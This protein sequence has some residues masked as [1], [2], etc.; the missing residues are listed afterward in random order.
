MGLLNGAVL[1]FMHGGLSHDIQPAAVDWRIGTL[2][3]AGGA[4]L[5]AAQGLTPASS[6]LVAG[7]ATVLGGMA[8]Y[9]RALRRFDGWPDRAWVFAP[10][11]AGALGIHW[12]AS[13]VPDLA[14]RVVMAS[15]SSALML[16][17]ASATVWRGSRRLGVELPREL[18]SPLRSR[19]VLLAFLLL[20]AGFML[21]RAAYALVGLR[22]IASILDAPHWFLL[23]TQ[24]VVGILPLVGTTVFLTM[25]LERIRAHLAEAASTDY[26]TGLPNRRNISGNGQSRFNAAQRARR[27][28]ALALIDVDHFK[29]INDL[30]GHDAGD[31]ALR[32]L[33]G[34]LRA[35]CRGPDLAGRL[36]GEEFVLLLDDVDE[37]S[38][39]LAARRLLSVVE[40]TPLLLDTHSLSLT[41]SIGLC[42]IDAADRD[43][44]AMLRRADRALYR[45]KA[46]GRNRVVLAPVASVHAP[47]LTLSA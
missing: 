19:T 3:L 2:L 10:V 23:S 4:L 16:F 8:L 42:L 34:I 30:Y 24:L 39:L 27:G 44:D 22:D 1:G 33:G 5:L 20:A 28:F 47:S 13:V 36:G 32:H 11:W 21:F 31:Q 29:R 43:F 35:Q 9:W 6:L 38:G 12:F 25:C 46:E 40:E 18:P 37:A 14:G 41:V 17:A 45:A 7:N 26:L 15:L